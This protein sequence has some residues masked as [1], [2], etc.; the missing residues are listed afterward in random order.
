MKQFKTE[1]KK[2]LDLHD[3]LHL[4]QQGN[5][6][7]RAYLQRVRCSGQALLQEPHRHRPSLLPRTI[8]PF[9]WPSTSD[10]RTVTVSDTG[11]GMTN[12]ELETNLGTI[13]HSGSLE[14]KTENAEKQGDDVDI[15][16]Q[17]GVG[18]YSAFMVGKEGARDLPRLRRGRGV[19]LGDPTASRATPSS[20]PPR[21]KPPHWVPTTAPAS[22]CT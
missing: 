21:K 5:L 3:Q 4:H 6:P 12:D 20:P 7:A 17:F 14:F 1:S 22:S 18:F 16:G 10:A 8:L 19:H 11:I 2:L 15:I 13:A 9:T